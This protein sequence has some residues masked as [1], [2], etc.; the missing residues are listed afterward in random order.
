MGV[1]TFTLIRDCK[2]QYAGSKRCD[3]CKYR[4]MCYTMEHCD[5]VCFKCDSRNK[6]N[7]EIKWHTNT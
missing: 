1:T 5:G 2:I 7:E 6:C 4:F 3:E